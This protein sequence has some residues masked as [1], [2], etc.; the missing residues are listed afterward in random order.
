[1]IYASAVDPVTNDA[2]IGGNMAWVCEQGSQTQQRVG[3]LGN[4]AWRYRDGQGRGMYAG[5][6]WGNQPWYYLNDG[7]NDMVTTLTVNPYGLPGSGVSYA[8][9]D[10][11][12]VLYVGGAFT[13]YSTNSDCDFN[14][15]AMWNWTGWYPVGSGFSSAPTQLMYYASWVYALVGN[16]IYSYNVEG[17][18]IGL[19]PQ[20]HHTQCH[21]LCGVALR[22]CA[23]PVRR[24]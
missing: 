3:P 20:R 14:H 19:D 21:Q 4:V 17:Q 22:L 23:H 1:M 24:R 12:S 16:S 2:F 7:L 10:M 13:C 6:S 11:N 8:S 15:V 9:S 5:G 18:A